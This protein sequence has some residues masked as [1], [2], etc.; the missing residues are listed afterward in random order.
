MAC[1]RQHGPVRSVIDSIGQNLVG[2]TM[3]FLCS[4]KRKYITQQQYRSTGSTTARSDISKREFTEL[5]NSDGAVTHTASGL[6]TTL[7]GR[8]AMVSHNG[9]HPIRR[10]GHFSEGGEAIHLG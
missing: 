7:Q 5:G 6:A 10:K 4:P 9:I 3:A 8:T 1:H 2:E